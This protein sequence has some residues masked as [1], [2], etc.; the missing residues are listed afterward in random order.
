MRSSHVPARF[1]EIDQARGVAIIMMVTFH[2]AFDLY[3]LGIVPIPASQGLWRLLA[4]STA[5]LFLL[6][7]GISLSISSSYAGRNLTR[8]EF[9]LKYVTRG[10][11]IFSL[12]LLLTAVTWFLVPG[13]FI[14]FG[15]LHLIGIAVMLSPLYVRYLWSNLLVG[16]A[17]IALGPLVAGLRG[18]SWLLWAGIH[19]AGFASIDYTPLVPWLGVVLIGVFAGKLL[20][21]GGVRRFSAA[22]PSL[23]P[24]EYLGRHSLAIYLVHQPVILGL[25]LLVSG[26]MG[27]SPTLP[28]P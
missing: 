22:I 5:S 9:I 18:T 21:P 20:Y 1:P 27:I 11:F 26:T 15:I 4:L 7:V 17:I 12:G 25:I 8:R 10:A 3:F 23:P 16:S 2:I 24:L 14:R 6:L 28:F 19:P 13:G